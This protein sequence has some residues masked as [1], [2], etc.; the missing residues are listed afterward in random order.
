M[1]QSGSIEL[2]IRPL[3]NHVHIST[4]KKG[5]YTKRPSSVEVKAA[6]EIRIDKKTVQISCSSYELK[7]LSGEF[8]LYF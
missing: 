4:Y 5:K 8:V 1:F 6:V 2:K 7:K 3:N